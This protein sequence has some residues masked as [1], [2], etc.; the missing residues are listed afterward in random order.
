MCEIEL[1]KHK[2]EATAKVNAVLARAE[3]Q[4]LMIESLHTSVSI[5]LSLDLPT[6]FELILF[7]V[8]CNIFIISVRI[9]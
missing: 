9:G 1:Q 5:P 8:S 6:L 4:G 2:D 3:E 7:L